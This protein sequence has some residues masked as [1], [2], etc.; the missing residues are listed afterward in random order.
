M[1]KCN[2][3]PRPTT[4]SIVV[5]TL[6]ITSN[7]YH[8]P[9]NCMVVII[10]FH[11]LHWLS[12]TCLLPLPPSPTQVT[13]GGVGELAN[14]HNATGKLRHFPFA[15]HAPTKSGP[16]SSTS[17]PRNR[18]SSRQRDEGACG[19][20]E[21]G[22]VCWSFFAF[23]FGPFQTLDNRHAIERWQSGDHGILMEFT[24]I[25]SVDAHYVPL[26]VL[27]RQTQGHAGQQL[28]ISFYSFTTKSLKLY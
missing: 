5:I 21:C 22:G 8:L 20:C 23:Y 26:A 19:G 18:R 24:F 28:T 17:A 2:I 11:V 15:Q 16:T 25:M 9:H 13:G 27:D 12:T 3:L 1:F 6:R 10:L 14:I 7:F 4:Q